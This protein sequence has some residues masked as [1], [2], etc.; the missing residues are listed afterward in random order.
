[1]NSHIVGPAANG[2]G[3]IPCVRGLQALFGVTPGG[4]DTDRRLLLKTTGASPTTPLIV[5]LWQQIITEFD[6]SGIAFTLASEL[7][8]GTDS[9]V[10]VAYAVP[11][12]APII[13]AITA[14]RAYYI[15]YTEGTGG[16]EGQAIAV[17]RVFGLGTT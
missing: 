10:E 1:M 8:D 7:L 16:T 17:A 12:A 11:S 2:H 9:Q 13:K 6:A 3:A 14:D 5:E 15:S 4:G